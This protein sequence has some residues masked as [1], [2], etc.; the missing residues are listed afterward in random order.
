MRSCRCFTSYWCDLHQRVSFWPD[1]FAQWERERR[2][3]MATM[4]PGE[5]GDR[6]R[7]MYDLSPVRTVIDT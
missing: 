1:R 4:T 7:R 6:L 2:E 5:R 3:R